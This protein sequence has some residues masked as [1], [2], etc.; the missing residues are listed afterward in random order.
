MAMIELSRAEPPDELD[1]DCKAKL[2]ME[3]AATGSPVWNQPYV[4]NALLQS[5]HSKC[6]YCEANIEEESKYM[7]V[8]HFR[9]K[10]DFPELVLDWAN[11]LPSCKRCNGRKSSH[12][13]ETDGMILNPFEDSPPVHLFML[14]YR[15]RWKDEIGRAT[16]DALYL[17]DS[18]RMVTVRTKIGDAVSAALDRIRGNLEEYLTTTNTERKRRMVVRGIEKLLLESL[19][20]A[21]YSATT[22]TVLLSDPDYSWIRERLV[23]NGLWDE[24]GNLEDRARSSAL[25]P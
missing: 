8:D 24:F 19:P 6:C 18:D 23:D 2:T 22:A 17:N 14:N 5:S 4:R 21:E 3:F 9:C 11:L 25:L 16:I 20:P 1:A 7:E 15:I 13:V 10:N 12:N